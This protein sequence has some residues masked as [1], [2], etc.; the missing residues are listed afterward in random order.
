MFIFYFT[1]NNIIP[2]RTSV[3]LKKATFY[4]YFFLN[5]MQWIIKGKHMCCLRLKL[6]DKRQLGL[7]IYVTSQPF[8]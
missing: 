6:I 5:Y 1:I 4:Y 3:Y 8:Q 2:C 7:Y